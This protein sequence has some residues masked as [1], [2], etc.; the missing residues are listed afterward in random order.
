MN[1]KG[2]VLHIRN[3][4][5]LDYLEYNV[6][7]EGFRI[8]KCKFCDNNA[9]RN[10]GLNFRETCCS[11]ECK[12][13]INMRKHT[14]ETKLNLSNKRKKYLN[15]NKDKNGWSLYKNE[16]TEPEKRFRRLLE[17]IENIEF[18][19]YYKIPNSERNYELDFSIV[20]TKIAFEINGEQHYNRDGTLAPYYQERH[21]YLEKLGWIVVEIHY[22]LC[23]NEEVIRNII[24]ESLNQNIKFTE[25]KCNEI[26]NYRLKLKEK[27]HNEQRLYKLEKANKE[28]LNAQKEF[29]RLFLVFNIINKYGESLGLINKLS[30]ALGVTPTQVR[31]IL[32]KY[33]LDIKLRK[34]PTFVHS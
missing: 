30:H 12:S 23:F 32:K 29:E 16:E 19:Q 3:A 33:S 26:I 15:E 8:P 25:D 4:H 24:I 18:A 22:Q 14:E 5:S 21:D 34:N 10:R 31:R 1:I 6:Q 13:K 11:K 9:L 20:D 28:I 7:Y 27:K 2:K 17:T